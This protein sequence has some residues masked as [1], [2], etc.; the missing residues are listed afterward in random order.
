MRGEVKAAAFPILEMFQETIGETAG[1]I[2]EIERPCGFEEMQD[3]VEEEG[4]IV[5]VGVEMRPIV[6]AGGQQAAIA[7]KRAANE[8]QR[9]P[10]RVDIVGFRAGEFG[11]D[12]FSD[13]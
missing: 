9:A 10:G 3:G 4:V 8:I 5:Q 7:P 2:K 6:L 1:E 11:G 13:R 12:Q